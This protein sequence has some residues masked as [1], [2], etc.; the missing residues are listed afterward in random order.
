[1]I[2]QITTREAWAAGYEQLRADWLRQE[3]GWGLS[4]LVRQGMAAWMKMWSTQ[5]SPPETVESAA[6]EF[7]SLSPPVAPQGLQSQLTRELAN[8]IL[9]RQQ[10]VAA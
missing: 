3:I 6:T 8:M 2:N 10:E 5:A 7:D 9:H 1:M 4:L